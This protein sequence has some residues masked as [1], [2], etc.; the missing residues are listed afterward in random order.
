[1]FFELP[2]KI[3]SSQKRLYDKFIFFSKVTLK[4][5]L[6]MTATKR[7]NNEEYPKERRTK[8]AANTRNKDDKDNNDERRTT[9]TPDNINTRN[10]DDNN[11]RRTMTSSDS[12]DGILLFYSIKYRYIWYNAKFI[13]LYKVHKKAVEKMLKNDSQILSKLESIINGQK[14]IENRIT[15]IENRLDNNNKTKEFNEDELKVIK[16]KII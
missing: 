12:V 14:N 8:I 10:K 16:I 2:N 1:M 5:S 13:L 7:K 9:M 15:N 11:E 3:E 6:K 4:F